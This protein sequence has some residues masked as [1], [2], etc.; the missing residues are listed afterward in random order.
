MAANTVTTEPVTTDSV[1]PETGTAPRTSRRVGWLLAVGLLFLSPVCAEYVIGYDTST[2]DPVALLSGLLI[3]GPLYGAPAL[4]IREFAR[5]WG[6]RW[7]GIVAFTLAFGVLQAGVV[8]QSLFSESYRDI[9][10]WDDD[11]APTWVAALGLS[12]TNTV[13]FL[14]GHTIW[15]FCVPIA[16]V[17]SL[18]PT[19]ARR[20]WLRWPGLAVTALLYLAAA[21]LIWSEHQKTEADHASVTQ[22]TGCFVVAAILVLLA[23]TAGRRTHAARDRAVPRP[24]VVGVLSFAAAAATNFVPNSWLGVGIALTL[25]A[26]GALLVA[27]LSRSPRWNARHVVALAAGPLLANASVGFLV[28]PLGKVAPLAKYG[29]NTTMVVGAALLCLWAAHRN[30]PE[31]EATS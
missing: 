1:Q 4:L 17:E 22:I 30:R 23:L 7:P 25:F 26:A 13:N 31:R 24:Y 21:W 27:Y 2:G 16:L 11:I 28:E 8:D 9:E 3:L 29:H 10:S 20:P 5:R 6:V 14:A 18:S 15:S 12:G 19:R